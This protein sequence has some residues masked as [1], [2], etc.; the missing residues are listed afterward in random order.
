MENICD[1]EDNIFQFRL[2]N[3]GKYFTLKICENYLKSD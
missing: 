2:I 1:Y 3:L